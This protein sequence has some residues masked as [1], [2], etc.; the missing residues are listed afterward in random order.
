[1]DQLL[2]GRNRLKR[3]GPRSRRDAEHQIV[4]TML[5]NRNR[6]RASGSKG[7][8][9]EET[10]MRIPEKPK[11]PEDPPIS[12]T[13]RFL[14]GAEE[15]RV[16][17]VY[18]KQKIHSVRT[19]LAYHL[20][21]TSVRAK[22]IFDTGVLKH[23]MSV[24]ECGLEEGS[25]VNVIILPP[26]YEGTQAYDWLARQLSRRADGEATKDQI[27]DTMQTVMAGKSALHEALVK[28]GLLR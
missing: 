22:L 27:D 10:Y 9:H 13:F 21:I 26:L 2:L 11:E 3:M 5:E 25:V 6:G 8:G 7:P 1:M 14:A 20:G 4:K 15:D 28:K 19:E 18:P 12:V 16:L 24:S 17:K 23:S